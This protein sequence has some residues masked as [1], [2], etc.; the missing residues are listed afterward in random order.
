MRLHSRTRG[1]TLVELLVVIAIIGALV[2]LLLPAV[3]AARGAARSM[4]CK[5]NLKQIGLALHNY[6]D[7]YRAFPPPLVINWDQGTGWW[8]WYVRI[9]PF[10]EQTPLYAGIDMRDDAG[11]M[12]SHYREQTSQVIPGYLCP[13]DPNSDLVWTTDT[14]WQGPVAFA[15]T[16]YI[17]VSGSARHPNW[18]DGCAGSWAMPMEGNG[19]FAD[20]NRSLGMH[21]PSDGTSNTLFVGERPVDGP[22]EW[23]WWAMGSGLDCRGKGDSVLDTSEGLRRG[24]VGGQTDLLHFW[25][26][27]PAGAHFLFA[28]GAVRFLP[29]SI[30][31][32]TLLA[33]STRAG[34][35]P[36]SLQ[37][38]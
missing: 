31:Y 38:F 32:D 7:Q 19:L 15:H 20:V 4:Q 29:Y 35:E 9:L 3:Q 16:N 36:V 18:M 30:N 26:L 17:G 2:A 10:V 13:S 33:L 11:A 34:N 28:D 5:N 22:G 14:W 24:K 1:F 8:Y 25:S 21:D 27:H 23:G 12:A 37:D 6:H